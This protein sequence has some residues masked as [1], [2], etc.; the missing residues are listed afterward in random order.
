[1][2][3]HIE[4]LCF[5]VVIVFQVFVLRVLYMVSKRMNLSGNTLTKDVGVIFYSFFS[6]ALSVVAANLRYD[7]TSLVDRRN[8]YGSIDTTYYY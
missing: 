3:R 1:M 4:K 8:V 5:V 6:L 7:K 2:S